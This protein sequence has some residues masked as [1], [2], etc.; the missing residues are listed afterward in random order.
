MTYR[1]MEEAP[2]G[3]YVSVLTR[4][5]NVRTCRVS[6]DGTLAYQSF[7]R[8]WHSVDFDPPQQWWDGPVPGRPA[9]GRVKIRPDD[10][11]EQRVP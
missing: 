5:C 9:N 7:H 1:P 11:I 10:E 8:D 6:E 2:R 3:Y 4:A